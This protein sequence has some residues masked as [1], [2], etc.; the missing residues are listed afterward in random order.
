M[1]FG[2]L[3]AYGIKKVLRLTKP[4][5]AVDEVTTPCITGMACTGGGG[6]GLAIKGQNIC[7]CVL[8]GVRTGLDFPEETVKFGGCT[9]P[10]TW[11]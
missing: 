3:P 9:P 11:K 4:L 5:N 1:L 6:G 7:K 8:P 2:A 10:L